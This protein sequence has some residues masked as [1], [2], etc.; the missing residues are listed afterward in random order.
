MKK[1]LLTGGG[2]AGHVTPNLALLPALQQAGY[3][4]AYMGSFDGIER[5]LIEEAGL[6]YMPISTGKLRR[7]LDSQNLTDPFRVIKGFFQARRYLKSYAPQVVFS[8]GGFVSVPVVRAAASLGIPCV[9]HESDLSPGLAN[10]LCIPVAYGICCNFPETLQELPKGKARIT[11]TPI[12]RELMGGDA[13][14][15][16][17]RCGFGPDKP[18]LLVMG[19][20]QGAA[21]V[22]QAIRA[23]L[24]DLLSDFYVAHL[25]GP[26]KVDNMLLT[27]AGYKQIE[28]AKEDLK[29]L[30]AMADIV[31]SRAGANAIC[32]LAALRKPALLIPLPSS[33]SRGDQ[34]QNARSF[35][36]QHFSALLE[37]DYLTEQRLLEEIQSLYCQR[38]SYIET[39]SQ[40]QMPDAIPAI[41]SM[42]EEARLSRS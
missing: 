8:K 10:R 30:L 26:G 28:Y 38:A 24:P 5:R 39:L 32:E 3:H 2:T 4:T 40:G 22:N 29:D 13:M 35:A 1:I 11:G 33:R 37:E 27:R 31:V 9:L 17:K 21:S 36:A 18:V 6:L 12:R 14:T 16:R 15:G 19:G 42:I 25:C 23:I 7:Y 41:L 34:I 20:S